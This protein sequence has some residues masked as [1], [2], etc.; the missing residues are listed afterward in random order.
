[1]RPLIVH[2]L[3]YAWL[4]HDVTPSLLGILC[5]VRYSHARGSNFA[6]QSLV[7]TPSMIAT[8]LVY[9][10]VISPYWLIGV[11]KTL[12]LRLRNFSRYL[13]RARS[14]STP[15]GDTRQRS[16]E[17][18]ESIPPSASEQFLRNRW[19]ACCAC[20]DEA[21]GKE[22]PGPGAMTMY[23]G[24]DS[25]LGLIVGIGIGQ[26][27]LKTLRLTPLMQDPCGR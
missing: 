27:K 22:G 10:N 9:M 8:A 16:G 1:M 21:K 19:Q 15:S 13:Y 18:S 24:N 26:C 6:R 17:W 12:V 5:P 3:P 7:S 25:S 2:S 11:T 4:L 20:Q 14:A 23:A